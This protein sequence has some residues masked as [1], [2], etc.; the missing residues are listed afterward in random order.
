MD[1][2][3]SILVDTLRRLK[4]PGDMFLDSDG[5]ALFGKLKLLSKRNEVAA[6]A[7]KEIERRRSEAVE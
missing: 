2:T 5:G 7:L 3:E 1:T 6:K 4:V